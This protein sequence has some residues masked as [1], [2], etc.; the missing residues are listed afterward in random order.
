MWHVAGIDETL[1]DLAP[2]L[3]MERATGARKATNM[4]F[5]IGVSYFKSVHPGAGFVQRVPKH[6]NSRTQCFPGF[7]NI[8]EHCHGSPVAMNPYFG[9]K[10][11][12]PV[13]RLTGLDGATPK[14]P[15]DG[16]QV[17]MSLFSLLASPPYVGADTHA[18][19]DKPVVLDGMGK[20]TI[21]LL[22]GSRP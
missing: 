15:F 11:R 8:S 14:N 5:C 6:T 4:A 3:V 19:G 22:C 21:G 17:A 7:W 18:H 16:G 2:F 9:W 10:G 13:Q 1:V 20:Q 12:M